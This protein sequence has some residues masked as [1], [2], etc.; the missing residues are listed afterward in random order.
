MLAKVRV[1]WSN[2]KRKKN[3][4]KKSCACKGIAKDYSVCI[5]SGPAIGSIG[6]TCQTLGH[7]DHPAYPG[8]PGHPYH[9][10]LPDQACNLQSYPQQLKVYE[11]NILI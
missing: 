9:L 2:V 3:R 10:G 11:G 7:P 4:I 6:Y 5:C 8:H 1:H